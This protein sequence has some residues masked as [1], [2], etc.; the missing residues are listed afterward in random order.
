MSRCKKVEQIYAKVRDDL[1]SFSFIRTLHPID[2]ALFVNNFVDLESNGSIRIEDY[3]KIMQSISPNLSRRYKI[4]RKSYCGEN[5]GQ[6]LP[7][8]PEI[9][10]GYYSLIE[11]YGE[12]Q[13]L[14]K[15]T[16][17]LVHENHIVTMTGGVH[18][19]SFENLK[20]GLETSSRWIE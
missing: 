3:K 14:T 18:R 5:A 2:Q 7:D 1:S 13:P 11:L 20:Y 15:I 9:Q 6:N 16:N 17:L 4:Y 8:N 12:H 10:E 19:S